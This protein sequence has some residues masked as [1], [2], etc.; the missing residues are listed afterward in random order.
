MLALVVWS[1]ECL[2]SLPS[3]GS[4]GS[5]VVATSLIYFGTEDEPPEALSAAGLAKD[6]LARLLFD[7]VT[8]TL[9]PKDVL[10]VAGLPTNNL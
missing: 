1:L 4:L 3:A 5:V 8:W 9:D 7:N 6:C 10:A 2:R